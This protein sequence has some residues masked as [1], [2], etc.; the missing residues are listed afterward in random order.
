M[1]YNKG[2]AA[3]LHAPPRPPDYDDKMSI[4]SPLRSDS[5]PRAAVDTWRGMS[6]ENNMTAAA[7]WRW[8]NMLIAFIAALI[9]LAATPGAR[10]QALD[11]AVARQAFAVAENWVRRASVSDQTVTLLATEVRAVHV[12][13][14]RGG[15][16]IGQAT[17]AIDNVVPDSPLGLIDLMPLLQEAVGEALREAALSFARPLDLLEHTQ[18]IALD[19]QFA[20]PL[21]PIRLN[22]LAE[23][24]EKVIVSDDGLAMRHGTEWT[25]VWPGNSIAANTHLHGQITRLLS[26]LGLP[27]DRLDKIGTA[28]GPPLYKFR[29]IHLVRPRNGEEVVSLRRGS[30]TFPPVVLDNRMVETL[31]DQLANHLIGRQRENGSFTGT[32]EPTSGQYQPVTAATTDTA[33]AAYTLARFAKLHEGQPLQQVAD[34]AAKRALLYLLRPADNGAIAPELN[35][36]P[37]IAPT[38]MTLLPLLETAGAADMKAERDRLA[39]AL[40]MMQRSTGLFHTSALQRAQPAPLSSQSLAAAAMVALYDRTR[41]PKT[42]AAAQAALTAIWQQMNPEQAPFTLPWLAQAELEL[43]RLGQP[44]PNLARLTEVG[45]DL[46]NRQITPW[47]DGELS[48]R[49]PQTVGGISWVGEPNWQSAQGL[50][51]LGILLRNE[52]VVPAAQRADW[53]TH[54]GLG[55]RFLAQLTLQPTGAY[56]VKD[57]AQAVGGLRLSL[58]DNN[59]P[60][61]ATATALLAVTELRHSLKE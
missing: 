51:G 19:V 39:G 35:Q 12:T 18:E 45:R 16:T 54:A 28:E 60:L 36:N 15:V 38:A 1:G 5:A 33:L 7:A 52:Q 59:Q 55:A 57:P 3:T 26:G 53:I 27:L 46:M 29:V 6:R 50:A 24:P 48:Q 14:R 22:R 32:Y 49:V 41:D 4:H 23:L 47:D 30:V 37:E 58:W 34:D 44:T 9:L 61:Y 40:A 31:A 2:R 43:A 21:E 10:G 25:W 17:A 8:G 13:L 20:G 42:L 56:Y 11:E